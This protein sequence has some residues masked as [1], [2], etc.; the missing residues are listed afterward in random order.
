MRKASGYQGLS[1]YRAAWPLVTVLTMVLTRHVVS[2]G[3]PVAH[4]RAASGLC[5]SDAALF[6]AVPILQPLGHGG[7]LGSDFPKRIGGLWI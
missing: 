1:S 7:H 2:W 3:G 5:Y 6:T 4:S